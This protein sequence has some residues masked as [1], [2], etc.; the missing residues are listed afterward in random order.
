MIFMTNLVLFLT[1]GNYIGP[2]LDEDSEPEQEQQELMQVDDQP[3]GQIVLHE[4][5]S[6]YPSAEEVFGQG[7]ETMVQEEDTQLLTVPIIA[8]IIE[9]KSFVK[10]KE[11]PETSYKK[12]F[13]LDLMRY[14]DLIRNV[15]VVGHLHH[16]KTSFMDM[17]VADS[18]QID[19]DLHNPIRYTDVHTVER[20][21]LVSI[22]SMP[23]S[24]VLQ[25]QKGKSYLFNV[26][27]TPGHSNFI[28]EIS[29]AL[30]IAD[31]AVLVVDVV[32]GVMAT[33]EKIIQMLV[34]ENIPFILVVNKIDRLILE[35]KLPPT[36]AY[37]KIKHTIEEVN[38][39]LSTISDI[40]LSPEKGN[41]VFAAT[42]LGW[43]FS[44][45]SFAHKYSE[46]SQEAFD[47]AGFARRL[48]GDIYFD[49][50]KRNFRK[51]PLDKN[52]T[53]TFVHFVLEPLYKLY[54]QVV[55]EEPDVLSHTLARLDI[56]LKD[57]ELRSNVKPLLVNVSGR[58]LGYLNGLI[59]TMT[60]HL[61]DPVQAAKTKIPSIYTGDLPDQY[62]QAMLNCDP[63][64]PLMI[65]IVKLYNAENVNKFEAFGRVLSGT[66]KDGQKVRVLG[67]D[68]SPEDDEDMVV[69]E[70]VG[71]SVFESRY[72]IGVTSVPAGSYV[73]L[74]GVEQ[75]IVKFATITGLD[76]EPVH[77]LKPIQF[78]TQAVMKVA[79]EPVNPTELPK[80]LEGLRKVNK[81]YPILQTKVEESGEH[82][83]I[84]TGELYLDSVLHDLRKI[85]A[86]ID[87][88]VSDPV[89]KFCE[90][91]LETSAIKCFADTPN[92]KNKLTMICEPL[93]KGIAEDIETKKISY[94][95][96]QK[97]VAKYF[98][99]K[100]DWDILSSRNVWAFGPD[101]FG[102][103]IL[104]NDTLP[105]E[106]DKK[107]LFS[108]KD[109]F[110]QGFQWASREGPLTDEPIRNVK[111]R[112]LSADLAMEPIYRG[113]GQIIPTARRVCYSS[114]L[115]ATPRLM[116][117][118]YYVEIQA[119][120]DTIEA[121]YTV[122]SRRRGHVTQDLPKPG[123]PLY[124]IKSLLP[125][126]DAAGFETDLRTHTMGQAFCQQYF[127]HWQVV[128]G[129]PLDKDIILRPLE[130]SQGPQL[131]RDFLLKTRRRKG[132]NEDVAVT[133]F[134]DDPMLLELAKRDAQVLR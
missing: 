54:G 12:E 39:F 24:L 112:I 3:Q 5:K 75:S 59:Q 66:V 50:E 36:D 118:V 72:K 134:F 106:T 31:G 47:V 113:G 48:W 97:Q 37:F 86:E 17:L 79:I 27:D 110:K 63:D 18:H 74:D 100:Y 22:K 56:H 19:V 49:P 103:N 4:D 120:S 117:P 101:D 82:V 42:G 40:R 2:D 107:L 62:G 46:S 33:T 7:V 69:K 32:E 99:E 87:V 129:D 90:T 105:A 77:I 130:P 43:S 119:P 26:M 30:R 126:I 68:Y 133:K 115:M 67:P 102:P 60:V 23:M 41:V 80:M 131:A 95:W 124:T 71:V 45:E 84:G 108:I 122:L 21:R 88:K 76:D 6:Y 123:S 94:K 91:V 127:D 35:L 98:T 64:G 85:Y 51:S 10:E 65:Q 114:F 89:V 55:G 58:F 121:V 16:G 81:S 15:A 20:D 29:C 92:K 61:P 1:K 53:R 38:S 52:H 132:L 93:E 109:S 78:N 116:E 8:P 44:L 25:N 111:F 57:K 70:V 14:P 9:E 11:M 13:L 128:P 34:T 83:L 28:D 125:A 104:L 73:L 96:P